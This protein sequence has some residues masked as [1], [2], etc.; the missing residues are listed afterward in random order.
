MKEHGRAVL[1]IELDAADAVIGAR[2]ID[3]QAHET[4][5]A[6]SP[7]DRRR[8]TRMINR[9][10]DPGF[11]DQASEA[12]APPVADLRLVSSRSWHK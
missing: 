3:R 8:L 5:I 11:R 2:L 10:D 1:I 4:A 7:Q 6:L 9:P 12:L